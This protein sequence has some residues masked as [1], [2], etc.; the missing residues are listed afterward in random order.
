MFSVICTTIGCKG[1]IFEEH[2]VQLRKCAEKILLIN[3]KISV[4]VQFLCRTHYGTVNIGFG[5]ACLNGDLLFIPFII[6]NIYL[7]RDI[8]LKYIRLNF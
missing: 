1:V 4:S 3:F 7:R 5:T 8:F 2:F 6:E